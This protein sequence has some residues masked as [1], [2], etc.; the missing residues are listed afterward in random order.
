MPLEP[1]GGVFCTRENVDM[2]GS[3]CCS[4]TCDV[5]GF[6]VASFEGL[7]DIPRFD[8]AS[9]TT[10]KTDDSRCGETYS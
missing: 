4:L 2:T 8:R 9:R 5:D 7:I 1:G 3:V 10:D 6:G